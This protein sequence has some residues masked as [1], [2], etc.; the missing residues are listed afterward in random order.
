MAEEKIRNTAYVLRLNCL[1]CYLLSIT[2]ILE[3]LAFDFFALLNPKMAC[4][5]CDLAILGTLFRCIERF[6]LT[7]KPRGRQAAFYL[8][9]FTLMLLFATNLIFMSMMKYQPSM[10]RNIM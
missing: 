2:F 7:K 9:I 1:L 5:V 6:L 10:P 8:I 3:F 4:L